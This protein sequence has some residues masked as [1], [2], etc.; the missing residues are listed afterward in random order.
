MERSQSTVHRGL[1]VRMKVG[2]LEALD[3]IAS[4]IL[5]AIMNVF[6][7]P[8]LFVLGIPVLALLAL[9]FGKRNKPDGFLLH[10]IR[11]YM[12]PGHFSAALKSQRSQYCSF[13]IY[14]K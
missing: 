12:T 5:A 7:F 13:K 14:E 4:L 11:Y 3:L 9:Y 2:G 10:L 1:D 8:T 6:G